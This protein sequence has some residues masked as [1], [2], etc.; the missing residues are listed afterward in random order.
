MPPFKTA[1]LAG[2][3]IR[4]GDDHRIGDIVRDGVIRAG[5]GRIEIAGQVCMPPAGM[6]T[7]TVPLAVNPLTAIL[8]VVSLLERPG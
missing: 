3:G 7:M 5:A 4:T 2:L 1:P 6:E 8:K